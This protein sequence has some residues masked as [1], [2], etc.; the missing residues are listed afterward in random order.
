MKREGKVL[1]KV[2]AILAIV[3][4][5][6]IIAF[7]FFGDMAIT[8]GVKVGA[9]K[10]LGVNVDVGMVHLG[11]LRG[12]VF[13]NDLAVDNPTG[14]ANKTLLKLKGASVKAEMGSLLSDTVKIDEIK[15]DGIDV[16]IEQ[17]GLGTNLQDL[18]NGMKAQAP[19]T[20]KA[21]ESAKP[22]PAEKK[23]A[24]KKLLIKKL[25]ITNTK[26][27]VRVL[28]GP[29]IP[30]N[31]KTITLENIGSGGESVDMA[32]LTRKILTAIS[33]AIADEGAGILPSD[34]TGGLKNGLQGLQNVGGEILN[35][36]KGVLEQGAGAIQGIFD[37][38]K[39]K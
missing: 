35:Q 26:V 22:A 31:L 1:K 12:K 30:L 34:I 14:Y 6:L 16:D 33:Q 10:A 38:K 28:S 39:K 29:E 25:E 20:E 7:W 36:G 18:L 21:P 13:V 37:N 5:V 8:K 11:I 23:A 32:A 15:L 17:K 27:R 9:T 4:V 24:G 3:V 2:L 19:P